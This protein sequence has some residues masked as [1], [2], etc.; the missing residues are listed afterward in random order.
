MARAASGSPPRADFAR[1][2]VRTRPRARITIMP[3]SAH[4]QQTLGLIVIAILI[5]LFTLARFWHAIHWKSY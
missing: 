4:R 1:G 2:G 3:A 5:L